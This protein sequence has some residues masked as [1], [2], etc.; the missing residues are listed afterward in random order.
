V[1][2]KTKILLVDNDVDF[3]ESTKA[4]LEN[5]KYEVVTANTTQEA[6]NKVHYE[7]P[8]LII[9]ELMLEKHDS[10]FTFTKTIKVDPL[11]KNIPILMLTAVEEKTGYS[12][13]Q[14]LDGYW[15]KTDDY[16]AKPLEP[17]ELLKRIKALTTS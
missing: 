15:M 4:V 10:G 2:K 5:H 14:E 17:D 7:K 3:I 1:D 8:D 9:I 12:F 13:S 6:I 16:A 11:Y